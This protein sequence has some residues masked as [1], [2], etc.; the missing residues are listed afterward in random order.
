MSVTVSP[1]SQTVN[2]GGVATFTVTASGIKTKQFIYKWI[3]FE[4]PKSSAEGKDRNLVINNVRVEDA[5]SYY[6]CVTNEWS[7]TQCSGI[8]I[9]TIRGKLQ[10]YVTKS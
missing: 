10:C 2:E 3:K 8:V 1:L 6:I 7:N 9:L 5:G 4:G